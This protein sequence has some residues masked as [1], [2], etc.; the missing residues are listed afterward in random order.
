LIQFESVVGECVL[1]MPP[2][3][4][5]KEVRPICDK[6]NILMRCDEVMV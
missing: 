1:I 2:D 5:M 4:Y 6:Y 3:G